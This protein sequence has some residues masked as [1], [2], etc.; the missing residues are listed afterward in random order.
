MIYKT[1][2]EKRVDGEREEGNKTREEEKVEGKEGG[3]EG[4]RERKG[5][6]WGGERGTKNTHTNKGYFKRDVQSIHYFYV[7]SDSDY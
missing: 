1:G 3:R 4:A 2:R 5:E 6:G 7:V